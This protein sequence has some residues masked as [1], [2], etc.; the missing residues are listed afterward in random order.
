MKRGACRNEP[1]S[2]VLA[3][4]EPFTFTQ[5]DASEHTRYE[6]STQ[7]RH[8]TRRFCTRQ[9][10]A[11]HACMCKH[12][13][14]FQGCRLRWVGEVG[15]ME[16]AWAGLHSPW[17]DSCARCE[18]RVKSAPAEPRVCSSWGWH[19]RKMGYL[20]SACGAGRR[21]T[22]QHAHPTHHTPHT[23]HHTRTTCSESAS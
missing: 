21:P 10:T 14:K 7:I 16:T 20:V 3:D 18:D 23:T 19:V 9:S 12:R 2:R 1:Q 22:V 11:Q 13:V 17:E 15:A 5:R 4:R 6:S 8:D